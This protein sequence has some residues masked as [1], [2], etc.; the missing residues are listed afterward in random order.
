MYA[1]K[2]CGEGKTLNKCR[3]R[4]T[5]YWSER[6]GHAAEFGK[7]FTT[8]CFFRFCK[9]RAWNARGCGRP[10]FL[11]MFRTWL[12]SIVSTVPRTVFFSY[13]S[14]LQVLV[15]FRN[16]S[17]VANY[18]KLLTV[19]LVIAVELKVCFVLSARCSD[20]LHFVVKRELLVS[21]QP[22]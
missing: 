10:W 9:N 13:W 17:K 20:S 16:N 3:V 7:F 2:F 12:S 6:W 18:E 5:A 19:D 21:S 1:I 8:V 15:K 11:P 14:T 4:W 22:E